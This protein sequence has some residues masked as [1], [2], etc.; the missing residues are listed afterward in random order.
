M[1]NSSI[2]VSVYPIFTCWFKIRFG[3]WLTFGL[4]VI[5]FIIKFTKSAL[6]LHITKIEENNKNSCFSLTHGRVRYA[7][8]LN[9]N[10]RIVVD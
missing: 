9:G 5:V 3:S 6:N 10:D 8:A 2:F 1:C 4:K 7:M